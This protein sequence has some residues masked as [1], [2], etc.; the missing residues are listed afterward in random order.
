GAYVYHYLDETDPDQ[1]HNFPSVHFKTNLSMPMDMSDYNITDVSLEVKFNASVNIN[2]DSFFDWD[3]ISNTP[4][5]DSDKFIIGDSANFYV[6]LS[7]LSNSYP[8][9]VGDFETRDVALGEGDLVDPDILNI[10]ESELNYVNKQDLIAAL[11]SVLETDNQNFTLNLGLDIYCEDNR[12]NPGDQDKWN[13]LI[14][15]SAN[16]TVTYVKKIDPFTKISWN[17]IGNKINGTNIQIT[18]ASFNFKYKINTTWS[19]SAPLS[20]IKFYINNKTHAQGI[21]KL[22]EVPTSFQYADPD[23]SFDVTNLI[24]TDVNISTSIELYLKDNFELNE[25]LMISIA[26]VTLNISYIETFP[27]Y[28]TDFRLSLNNID[29]TSDPSIQI[30]VNNPLNISFK[31]LNQSL[32]HIIN[33]TVQLEGKV[34][35]PLVQNITLKQYDILINTS[36]LGIGT[37]ILTVI[38]EKTNYETKEVQ[39]LVEVTERM[40]ELRLYLNNVLKTDKS[41]ISAKFNELITVK[42]NY[43]DIEETPVHISGAT[44]NLL[45]IGQLSEMNSYYSLT[46]N[47]GNLN[48]GV[49]IFTIFAELENYTSQSIQFFIEVFDRETELLLYVNSVQKYEGDTIQVQINEFINITVAY[50]DNSTKDYI[51]GATVDLLGIDSLTEI[52][53]TYNITLSTNN[54][55]LGINV[56]TIYS[57]KTNFESQTIQFFI[58]VVERATNLN[59][60]LNGEDKTSDTV[61]DLPISSDLNITIKYFDIQTGSHINDAIIELIGEGLL[62]NF[63]ENSALKQYSIALNTSE[64]NMGIK[65]FTIIAQATSYQVFTLDIRITITS[66][67]TNISTITGETRLDAKSGQN[68]GLKIWLNNTDFGGIIKGAIISFEWEYGLGELTDVDNDGIYEVTLKNVKVGSH[69]ITITAYAGELYEFET[70]EIVLNV[71]PESRADLTW[72]VISLT[73]GIIGLATFFISYQKYFKYPPMVRKVRKLRKKIK[74]GKKLKPILVSKREDIIRNNI[75]NKIQI[76]SLDTL[77]PK[78]TDTILKSSVI[79]NEEMNVKKDGGPPTN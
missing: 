75:Q 10:T 66:I 45:G 71:I 26:N 25:T 18:N 22:S 64:L 34:I 53:N 61:F 24:S 78:E 62:R 56:L 43:E 20:E 32:N 40:T 48:K 14:F 3:P 15:K 54:L 16:L 51:T 76:F 47:T 52:N 13:Y 4:E 70:F 23:G 49:N 35:G 7:D 12:G 19:S 21:F 33:A 77:K 29:K 38:A 50:R 17:Q 46:L 59:L 63:T 6:E 5:I 31:Y 60:F 69:I 9:R 67:S 28:V 1:I 65:L 72:L 2:V 36:Q 41:N 8:F 74:K 79:K 30:P 39:I 57:Q 73:G 68:Y 37:S 42:I 27:D 11:N 58:N 44:V 55:S